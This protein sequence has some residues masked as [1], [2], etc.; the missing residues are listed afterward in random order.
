MPQDILGGGLFFALAAILW[1]LYL[2]PNWAKRREYLATERNALRLQQTLRVMAETS[3]I[4]AEVSYA[5]SSRSVNH[6]HRIAQDQ[7]KIQQ[8]QARAR[9]AASA[10]QV[11][12]ELR[13]VNAM[14]NN[15]RTRIRRTRLVSTVIL[16]LSVVAI[17]ISASWLFAGV[18]ELA[19]LLG[20]SLAT[21]L[22]SLVMLRQLAVVSQT[23]NSERRQL[24]RESTVPAQLD[25]RRSVEQLPLA[26]RVESNTWLPTELPK[27]LYLSRT[28]S[29]SNTASNSASNTAAHSAP[30]AAR[31]AVNLQQQAIRQQA[32]LIA[33]SEASIERVRQSEAAVPTNTRFARMGVVDQTQIARPNFD[34][35]LRRRRA[36]G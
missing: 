18:G 31:S 34:E 2:M 30:I 33:A 36:A 4:P 27:P 7:E 16:L 29:V 24:R 12:A 19:W 8:A 23:V 1:L 9:R 3:E 28:A 13:E 26:P 15:Q 11:K 32:E 20:A 25:T 35:A 6:Q 22:G 5:I 10:R 17:V 21:A 14:S